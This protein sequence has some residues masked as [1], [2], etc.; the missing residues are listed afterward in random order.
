MKFLIVSS[1]YYP[2]VGAAPVRIANLA[3]GL[4]K[5]GHEV[6]VLT[7]LP[8][9]PQ[10]RIFEGYRHCFS[11][12]EVIDGINVYRYWTYASVSTN[13]VRRALSMFAFAVTLWA[14]AFRRRKI[15]SY[16]WV[17]LQTPTI[18]SAASA[19]RLFKGL[20]G[21]K[22]LLN[23]SDLW[24]LTGVALGA[25]REGQASYRYMAHLESMLYR[26]CDAVIGQSEEIL[27]Y[28]LDRQPQKKSFLYRNLQPDE[29]SREYCTVRHK[30][31]KVVYAGMFGVAQGIMELISNVRFSELGAEMHLYGG[32]GEAEAIRSCIDNGL[33]GVYYH[34]FVPK[35][36]ID[37]VLCDCDV[38]IVPLTT[39]I[40]GAVP[41]KLFDLLPCGVPVLFCGGGEGAET[42]RRLQLGKVSAPGDYSSISENIRAFREMSDEEYESIVQRCISAAS[43]EFSFQEQMDRFCKFVSEL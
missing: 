27:K 20:Y 19:M 38:S 32:G 35:D 5:E 36:G 22:I 13:A 6:D 7:C 24:P 15:R 14:F 11:K 10:N 34:G 43:D 28:I 40:Y 4:H 12:K 3:Q 16:D 31:L 23:V 26:R 42:V 29:K 1:R 33:P 2:E 25:M 9:H 18:V 41:S 37:R 8:N 21:K 39:C 17:I 30:P